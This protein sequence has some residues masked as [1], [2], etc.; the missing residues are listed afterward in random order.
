MTA[1]RHIL[2]VTAVE[3]ERMALGTACLTAKHVHVE[4]GGIGRANAAAT[5]A[6]ALARVP[7]D[8][9]ISVGIAGALPAQSPPLEGVALGTVVVAS[10]CVYAEEGIETPDGFLDMQGLG[11]PLGDFDG[12]RV[13]VCPALL[14]H[15]APIGVVGDVAT[16]ATCSGTDARAQTVARRTG[17]I[18]EAM[19]GAAAVHAARRWGAAAIEVRTISNTTG[20]RSSQRWDMSVGLKSL[21][22][23]GDAIA[24][25]ARL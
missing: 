1:G 5:V 3:A 20:D 21:H 13:P 9:V 18:A 7:Y 10:A 25:L 24:A 11:F 12:N 6:H 22:A 17:A 23:V 16:V 14:A 2:V 15:F 19:E 4:V 8:T